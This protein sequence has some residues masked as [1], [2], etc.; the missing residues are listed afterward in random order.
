MKFKYPTQIVRF[1]SQGGVV[2]WTEDVA[3]FQKICT[4]TNEVYCIHVPKQSIVLWTKGGL[5][6]DCLPELSAEQREFI[7]T[8][9]TPEEWKKNLEF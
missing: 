7:I 5:I 8:G 9:W 1:E 3:T 6:Q 2:S 4:V